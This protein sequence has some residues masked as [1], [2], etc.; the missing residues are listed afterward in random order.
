MKQFSSIKTCTYNILSGGANRLE[1]SLRCLRLMNIDIPILTETNYKTR[2]NNNKPLIR[3][4]KKCI[5]KAFNND[6]KE[7]ITK[8]AMEVDELLL[9]NATQHAYG[10]IRNWYRDKPEHIPKPTIQ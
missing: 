9:S 5:R 3:F 1:Q 10:K 6:R 4:L 8:L 7:R 2:K